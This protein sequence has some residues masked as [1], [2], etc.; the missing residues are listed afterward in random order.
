MAAQFRAVSWLC[1][2]DALAQWLAH[3]SVVQR[4]LVRIRYL[5][6]LRLTVIYRVPPPPP[7]R[8]GPPGATE[9]ENPGNVDIL[10]IL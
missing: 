9:E 1:L 3:H 7:L 10:K 2:V 5:P 8:D 6:S 4:F